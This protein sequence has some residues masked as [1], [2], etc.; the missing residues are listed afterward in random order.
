MPGV[1]IGDNTV[2]GAGSVVTRDI[3]SNC[4]AYG[5]PCRV[6]VKSAS[7]TE[8]IFTGTKKSIGKISKGKNTSLQVGNSYKKGEILC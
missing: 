8:N 5:S 2:I 6:A 1:T 3:P 4:V 7:T